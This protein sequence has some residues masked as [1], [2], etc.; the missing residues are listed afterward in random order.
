MSAFIHRQEEKAMTF[1]HRNAQKQTAPEPKSLPG[2]VRETTAEVKAYVA[3]LSMR[4]YVRAQSIKTSALQT[5]AE[6]QVQVMTAS[7]AAGAVTLGTAGGTV[8]AMTGGVV[9]AVVGVVPALF[10]FGLSIPFCAVVGATVGGGT[11]VAV[12]GTTGLATGGC[13]GYYGYA[14]KE[15]IKQ[16]VTTMCC[17]VD[18]YQKFARGKVTDSIGCVSGKVSD[19]VGL[20]SGKVNGVFARKGGA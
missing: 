11:G 4:G 8:G 13:A 10:T 9:G 3:T 16:G 5:A 17:K 14:H 15:E 2:S 12:G 20:V 18:G 7:A 19:S 1:V 6:P